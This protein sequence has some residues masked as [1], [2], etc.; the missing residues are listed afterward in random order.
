MRF[1]GRTGAYVERRA[2]AGRFKKDIIRCHKRIVACEV[3][4]ALTSTPATHIIQNNPA[5]AV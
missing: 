3:H 1:D 5:P 2:K 4:R